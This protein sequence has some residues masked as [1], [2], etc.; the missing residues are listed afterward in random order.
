MFGNQCICWQ[1]I[2]NQ[3]IRECNFLNHDSLMHFYNEL[4][5]TISMIINALMT[6]V[7]EVESKEVM[8]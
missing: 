3:C 5:S 8:K 2:V 4:Y 7:Y 1:S 6:Y